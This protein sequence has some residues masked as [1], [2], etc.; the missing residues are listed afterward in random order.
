[1][2]IKPHVACA[3]SQD[4][5]KAANFQ[6]APVNMLARLDYRVVQGTVHTDPSYSPQPSHPWMTW[7]S[8]KP[9]QRQPVK[10][11][12]T[13]HV[14]TLAQS[15]TPRSNTLP[16]NLLASDTSF[17]IVKGHGVCHTSIFKVSVTCI[18]SEICLLQAASALSS[19]V[20]HGS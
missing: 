16:F 2:S 8:C 12:L 13:S 17:V 20:R 11:F 5:F 10:Y 6:G 18:C 15:D 3:A 9:G 7:W 1:M 14:Y 4:T 19:H